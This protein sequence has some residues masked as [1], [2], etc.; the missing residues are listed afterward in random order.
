MDREMNAINYRL[1]K[2][3]DLDS[4]FELTEICFKESN[5]FQRVDLE[6]LKKT[7]KSFFNPILKSLFSV[8][9]AKFYYYIAEVDGKIVGA[10]TLSCVK[11]KGL[12]SA[13]MTHPDHRRKG[14]AR[15]LFNM[16]SQKAIEHK[17]EFLWLDVDAQNVG[18]K[19]LYENEGFIQY[20]HY[21]IFEY[22]LN[23]LVKQ[24]ADETSLLKEI[25]ETD[26]NYIDGI[27]EDIFPK[28]YWKY[29]E[30][31]KELKRY[32][33]LKRR[34]LISKIA[35]RKTKHLGIFKS[36]NNSPDSY[37]I[38]KYDRFTNGYA[39]ES[40]IIKEKDAHSIIEIIPQLLDLLQNEESKK[41]TFTFSIH[42]KELIKNL[43]KAGFT[44]AY[45]MLEMIKEI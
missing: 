30:R 32:N 6:K 13:V 44:K 23:Q 12:I 28:E 35:S 2:K 7:I 16:A 20:Y 42:R 34:G 11:N 18:A 25:D 9:G 36:E 40:P 3:K 31:E 26:L 19:K 8:L 22:D 4:Y 41:L 45:E 37:M 15:K 5:E 10:T 33:L 29:K 39:I 27:L 21:G 14:I 38:L 43:E 1:L 17:K 24:K